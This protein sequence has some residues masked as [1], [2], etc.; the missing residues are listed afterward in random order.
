MVMPWWLVVSTKKGIQ[1]KDV[2]IEKHFLVSITAFVNMR[3]LHLMLPTGDDQH[4]QLLKWRRI[5]W[6][7]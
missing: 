2:Q 3:I 7:L 1:D 4:L 5:F 6:M